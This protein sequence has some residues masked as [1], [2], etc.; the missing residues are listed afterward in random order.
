[1]TLIRR[2]LLQI[3]GV[4]AA[5]PSATWTAFAQTAGPKLTQILK[6]DMEGQGLTVQETVVSIVEFPPGVSAPWHM[7]PSAQEML[8]ALDGNLVVEVDGRGTTG[9][10]L[11]ESYVIPGDI[12]HLARNDSASASAKALVVHS[13]GEKGKP[14]VVA[15]KR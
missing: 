15:V 7:H 8:Y 9:V 1:M 13:R 10:K 2:E 6:K 3:A 11:G 14:F 12:A 5:V 4:L